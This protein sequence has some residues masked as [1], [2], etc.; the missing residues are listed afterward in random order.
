[1][2]KVRS[3]LIAILLL[4]ILI[5]IL[6]KMGLFDDIYLTEIKAI[7]IKENAEILQKPEVVAETE[8]DFDLNL[9]PLVPIIDNNKLE[10][11]VKNI[12]FTKYLCS[13][14]SSKYPS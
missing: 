12:K 6:W 3:V 1:M 4:V 7:D 8:E 9:I 14:A 10:Q 2:N 11:V 13:E 5:A